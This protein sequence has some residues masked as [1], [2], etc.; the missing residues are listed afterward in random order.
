MSETPSTTFRRPNPKRVVIKLWR[1]GFR[2]DP[3]QLKL[4]TAYDPE[5]VVF[6]NKT[7]FPIELRFDPSPFVRPSSS[8]TEASKGRAL[9]S[10]SELILTMDPDPARPLVLSLQREA[11]GWYEYQVEVTLSY[12]GAD[13]R[14]LKIEATGGSRPGIEIRR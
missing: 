14:S 11:E 9:A 6:V 7:G 1:Y 5:E 8:E 13:M 3:G 4:D 12:P 2:V 10:D